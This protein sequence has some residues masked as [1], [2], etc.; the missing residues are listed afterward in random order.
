MLMSGARH[1]LHQKTIWGRYKIF[2]QSG[3][4]LRFSMLCLLNINFTL[5]VLLQSNSE[6]P[7]VQVVSTQSWRKTDLLFYNVLFVTVEQQLL[8]ENV[9]EKN[10]CVSLNPPLRKQCQAICLD[11]TMHPCVSQVH[12]DRPEE[13]LQLNRQRIC[14]PNGCDTSDLLSRRVVM[15]ALFVGAVWG[16]SVGDQLFFLFFLQMAGR[17]G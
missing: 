9:G 8:L 14:Q 6:S 15:N 7:V 17:T 3:L 11:T 1:K 12:P 5:A 10:T 13:D 4:H 16:H 2:P